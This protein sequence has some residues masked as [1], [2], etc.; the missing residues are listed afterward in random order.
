[1]RGEVEG[2]AENVDR[3]LVRRDG[4]DCR[5]ITSFYGSRGPRRMNGAALGGNEAVP[6][7]ALASTDGGRQ[8]TY[9]FSARPEF[10]DS[11]EY[12]DSGSSR[13]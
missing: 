11:S 3:S 10:F 1:M 6:H 9:Y 7:K 4:P 12:G 2:D 8:Q 13:P 5:E